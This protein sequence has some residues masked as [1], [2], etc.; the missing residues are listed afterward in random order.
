MNG[1][2][3]YNKEILNDEIR[4]LII[5]NV[6]LMADKTETKKAKINLEVDK[7]RLFGK[8]NSLVVKRKELRT[9][10]AILN[11]IKFFNVLICRY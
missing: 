4:R 9:E 11:I 7:T 2:E 3:V 5:T 1:V 6:Q 8:K 10:I